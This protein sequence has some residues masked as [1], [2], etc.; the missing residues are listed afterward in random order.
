[1]KIAS[2]AGS[3]SSA[4]GAIALL[5]GAAASGVAA[6]GRGRAGGD[7]RAMPLIDVATYAVLVLALLIAARQYGVL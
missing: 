2:G 5:A 3:P 1:M 6:G 7:R 4:P